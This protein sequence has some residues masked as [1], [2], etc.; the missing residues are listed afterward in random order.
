MFLAAAVLLAASPV[1]C[2]ERRWCGNI[3][4]A[5]GRYQIAPEGESEYYV[6]QINTGAEIWIDASSGDVICKCLSQAINSTQHTVE[7]SIPLRDSDQKEH[8]VSVKIAHP[9]LAAGCSPGGV[10]L[11]TDKAASV[12]IHPSQCGL[13]TWRVE[14]GIAVEIKSNTKFR[15]CSEGSHFEKLL[16]TSVFQSR[17]G[18]NTNGGG[19]VLKMTQAILLDIFSCADKAVGHSLLTLKPLNLPSLAQAHSANPQ[20]ANRRIVRSQNHSP[21]FDSLHYTAR[22]QENSPIGATVAVIQARDPDSGKNGELTYSMRATVSQIS[23]SLF[24]I[25]PQTGTVTTRGKPYLVC[26][27]CGHIMRVCGV[28]VGLGGL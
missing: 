3:K 21:Q 19:P 14:G 12:Q 7:L 24:R 6:H 26:S 27:Y 16:I 8:S 22:A 23:E 4:P 13:Q 25:D 20:H 17:T 1:Q 15:M 10:S 28:G 2:R 18:T 11:P 5:G 9:C